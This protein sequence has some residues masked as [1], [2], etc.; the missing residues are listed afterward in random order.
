MSSSSCSSASSRFPMPAKWMFKVDPRKAAELQE[1]WFE[2]KLLAINRHL[3]IK[4][5]HPT[6]KWDDQMIT[7]K[8]K[9]CE[10]LS[11]LQSPDLPRKHQK[12]SCSPSSCS[13]CSCSPSSCSSSS[14][15]PD[16]PTTIQNSSCDASLHSA[17]SQVSDV[18]ELSSRI[19]KD[20]SKET[21]G[22]QVLPRRDCEPHKD[23][24]KETSGE[25]VLPRRD[26]EPHK[27]MDALYVMTNTLIPHMVKV[28]RSHDPD[29]RAKDLS[30][31]HPFKI[32]VCHRYIGYGFLEKLIHDKLQKKRVE[33]G[34]G[35][36]WFSIEPKQADLLIQAAMLEHKL[37]A[38]QP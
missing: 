16:T 21:S 28:G 26:C 5:R 27:D 10:L 12:R 18:Q 22:E 3:T 31:S 7:V 6:S 20:A 1:L 30:Q 38:P 13:P 11:Y 9:A 35:R 29:I 33:G 19:N 23:A 4:R 17:S 15:Q 24:S 14:E 8:N 25:Q 37:Q 36:E 2:Y 32:I 34:R